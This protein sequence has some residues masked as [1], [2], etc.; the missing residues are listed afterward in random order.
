MSKQLSSQGRYRA[1]LKVA[2]VGV[3]DICG[4]SVGVVV[5]VGV[6]VGT[7]LAVGVGEFVGKEVAVAVGFCIGNL[8]TSFA[9]AVVPTKAL[10]NT[11]AIRAR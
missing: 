10:R 2:L 4:V 11:S 8:G 5:C 3:K 6:L 1:Q 9:D 7:G